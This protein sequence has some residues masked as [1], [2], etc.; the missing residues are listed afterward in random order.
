MAKHRIKKSEWPL[1]IIEWEDS[2]GCSAHWEDID[3]LEPEPLLCRSVGWVVY[4]S[5]KAIVLVP[6]L[7]PKCNGMEYPQGCGDMTIPVSAVR[8]RVEIRPS[9]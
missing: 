5:D 9:R 8:N 7:A 4:E 3:K 2:M 1:V 6:H